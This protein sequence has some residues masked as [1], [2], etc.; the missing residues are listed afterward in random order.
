M[1][2][3]LGDLSSRAV[4]KIV[5]EGGIRK[6]TLNAY[7][8]KD[9]DGNLLS[10]IF[11][12]A[13]RFGNFIIKKF[14]EFTGR[15]SWSLSAIWQGITTATQFIW[16]FD[17][18]ASDESLDASINQAMI[19]LAGTAGGFLGQALGWTACGLVP[20]AVVFAFNEPLG[21]HLLNTV[22][23]EAFDE[24]CSTAAVLVRQTFNTAA[25][26]TFNFLYKKGRDLVMGRSYFTDEELA[27][28]RKSGEMTADQVENAKKGRQAANAAR[29][30]WSFAL[31]VEEWRESIPN[32][33]IKAFLEELLE[34]AAQA[35]IEAGYVLTQA[36][37]SFYAM[38]K[39]AGE[40]LLG[41][42][43][44]VEITLDR[45]LDSAAPA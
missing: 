31:K 39:R 3:K 35:C 25:R 45:S 5:S 34:E 40:A 4:R 37:D 12:A 27:E 21:I 2:I 29:K 28:K 6:F 20:G 9:N 16:N 17:W 23:Q 7:E 18:N 11:N 22:G 26:A 33:K 30:P 36:A 38:A 24:L 13:K 8:R 43:T 15:F 32:E 42:D 10:T 44:T 1:E 14:F 19:G 41:P